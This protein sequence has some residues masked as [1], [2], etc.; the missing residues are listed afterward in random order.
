MSAKSCKTKQVKKTAL[1]NQK[2]LAKQDFFE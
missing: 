2:S 1:K